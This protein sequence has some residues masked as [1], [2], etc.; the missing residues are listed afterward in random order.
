ADVKAV[1]QTLGGTVN[2]VV[3]AMCAG[4]LRRWLIAHDALPTEPL[5]AMVP[6][7][8]RT[9]EQRGTFGN[10]VS[11]L[12]VELPTDEADPSVR[13]QRM[14][15]AMNIAKEQHNAIPADVLQDFA[16]FTPPSVLGMASRVLNRVANRINPPFNVV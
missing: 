11:A 10:R 2:D 6:V 4:A 12:V 15:D 14:H 13:Y 1:K 16:Q 8:V 5:L 3:M 7:S 9:E